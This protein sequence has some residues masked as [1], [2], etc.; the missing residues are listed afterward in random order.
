MQILKR[1]GLLAAAA[2]FSF[3]VQAQEKVTN[4]FQQLGTALPTPNVYRNAAGAP[5]HQYW[6]QKAD[7]SMDIRVDEKNQRIYGNEEITYHN[8]SPDAL[9][10]LWI[11]LDQNVRAKDSDTYKA[12]QS[13]ISSKE[14]FSSV[15]N[16]EP[17]FDGELYP[18]DAVLVE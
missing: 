6:Q 16:M 10:Y 3:Q 9:S 12:S 13:S 4:S 2:V 5:G 8:Q 15:K 11:Q 14:S 1:F 7:Y 18:S 17:W